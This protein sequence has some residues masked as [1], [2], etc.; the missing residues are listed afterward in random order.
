MKDSLFLV[1]IFAVASGAAFGGSPR[2]SQPAAQSE[3]SDLY[4]LFLDKWTGGGAQVI[5]IVR[6]PSKRTTGR[7]KEVAAA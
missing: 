3:E 4:G 6:S 7:S 5:H 1:I 2:A